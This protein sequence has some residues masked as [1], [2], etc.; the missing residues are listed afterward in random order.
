[1]STFISI[2]RWE[3]PD[4]PEPVYKGVLDLWEAPLYV[5]I[6]SET[7]GSWRTPERATD[8]LSTLQTVPDDG[9]VP[10]RV[11]DVV[12]TWAPVFAGEL[13]SYRS[14]DGGRLD[15]RRQEWAPALGWLV[16]SL[17]SGPTVAQTWPALQSQ[18]YRLNARSALDV[19]TVTWP[20]QG[21]IQNASIIPPTV[22]QRWPAILLAL[23]PG[24]RSADRARLDVRGSEW[25]PSV[26]SWI[27]GS[28]TPLSPPVD[29]DYWRG[30]PWRG[31]P[32]V[33][34]PRDGALR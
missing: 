10:S 9:W 22:A 33:A 15:V 23:A 24:Y 30:R 28:G 17:P 32:K 21:W 11:N 5:P 2:R 16:T 12:G 29:P 13:A 26:S 19:R 18:S 1:M 8:R 7:R 3:R 25:S 34:W 20:S 27:V 31:H 14:G 4:R 6:G